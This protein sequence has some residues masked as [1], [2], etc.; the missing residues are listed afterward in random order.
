MKKL[1]LIIFIFNALV[2]TAQKFEWSAG[3]ESSN[4]PSGISA[5]SNH[6]SHVAADPS[7]NLIICGAY[8][9]TLMLGGDTLV[10]YGNTDLFLAKMDQA[11]NYLWK[12]TIGS[13]HQDGVYD[14]CVDGS[15]T[16]YIA[17]SSN[18]GVTVFTPDSAVALS[19]SYYNIM[20]FDSD[21][22]FNWIK[23]G[24]ATFGTE[25]NLAATLS[26]DGVYAAYAVT[27]FK[28]D[29]L[30]NVVW[31]K[32]GTSNAGSPGFTAISVNDNGRLALGVYTS[33]FTTS[34]G[35]FFFDTVSV[36]FSNANAS[37][38]VVVCDTSG[39]GL[40][41]DEYSA[42]NAAVKALAIDNA[43]GELYVAIDGSNTVIYFGGDTVVNPVNP[44][45]G[46]GGI[47]KYSSSGVPQWARAFYA[48]NSSML[49]VI[50]NPA[51]EVVFCG[52]TSN[53]SYCYFGPFSLPSAATNPIIGKLGSNGSYEWAKI[54]SRNANG[55][56]IDNAINI[57]NIPGNKY[58][59]GGARYD[60]FYNLTTYYQGCNAFTPVAY[61]SGHYFSV[62]S[63]NIEPVPVVN[64]KSYN[65]GLTV[66]FESDVQNGTNY[67]WNF[68]DAQTGT[69]VHPFHI[70]ADVG[71]YNVCLSADN[72]CGTG[73]YCQNVVL[74]GIRDVH[75][76]RIANT[77]Y[78]LVKVIGGFSST[79][80]LV[81]FIKSGSPD[82][83]PDSVLLINPG[84]LR[85]HLKLNGVDTGYYDLVYNSPSF[86]DTVIAA[87]HV[88]LPD[89]IL[90][91]INVTGPW[92]I[93]T[94]RW[95]VMKVTISNQ[96]NV[97]YYG[98]PVMMKLTP[99]VET[100]MYNHDFSDS[101]V[102][103]LLQQVPD[104]FYLVDSIAVAPFQFAAFLLPSIPAYS[105]QTI[106]IW[107]RTAVS[108]MNNLEAFIG[109]SYFSDS[110]LT[111]M[112]LRSVM[113]ACNFLPK[114]GQ[115]F[116][117]LLGYVPA[118]GCYVA[119][120]NLGCAIGNAIGE[121]DGEIADVI[122]NIGG[123]IL[124]CA[125]GSDAAGELLEKGSK[126]IIAGSLT[127]L[128]NGVLGAGDDCGGPSGCKPGGEDN[129]SL[130]SAASMDPNYKSGPQ[131]NT[132][133]NFINKYDEMNYVI[134]FE[135][136][137]T[138]T[139]PAAEVV[140]ID[141][142]DMNVFDLTTFSFTGF[143]ETDSLIDFNLPKQSFA[144]EIDLRPAK[145]AI[146]RIS[147]SLDTTTGILRWSFK[148]L[149][150]IT[151]DVTSVLADGFL[152]PNVTEP[153]GEGFVTYRIN[154][155]N[156]VT[157]L[158]S[159][160]NTAWIYFDGNAPVA[161]TPFLNTVDTVKPTSN[162]LTLPA[163]TND[164]IFT[165]MWT[166]ID[167]DAGIR[168]FDIYISINDGPYDKLLAMTTKDSIQVSGNN[169]DKYE[170]Y[171]IARD[172][173]KN[174]EAP[175]ANAATNPDAVTTIILTHIAENSVEGN[176][177]IHPNPAFNNFTITLN[178]AWEM[179]NVM[180]NIADV[181]GRVVHEQTLNHQ[182]SVINSQFSPGIYFVKV[183]DGEKVFTNKVVV[184]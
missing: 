140:V 39:S 12:E 95:G 183:M 9:D 89:S 175:P 52:E 57:T 67:Q 154:L 56:T 122:G 145:N 91:V 105:S 107:I 61:S 19:G 156:S 22:L 159:F 174:I 80:T 173:A 66:Y 27:A 85:T 43:T 123:T 41:G 155:K 180:L 171:S 13:I 112:G 177:S 166:G 30:G 81:K 168:S 103:A 102:Q 147:G 76:D 114:C 125:G 179:K 28:M 118:L 65:D 36:I 35:T 152:N 162:V 146:L 160:T 176:F 110:N 111:D 126:A 14:M 32:T 45:N 137:D 88:E 42:S 101:T 73:S 164:S 44:Q 6:Q 63:E 124:A 149:D 161:T 75:P 84:L 141:T 5:G 3:I 62:I 119:T 49:D 104:H 97:S 109:P 131:G 86:N 53:T 38:M 172:Y 25:I 37:K 4:I 181:T 163:T 153:E 157:H 96:S 23:T 184:E 68:G 132:P 169:G 74:D 46:F 82:I 31:Q 48:S 33:D 138:A 77:G 117:D 64:F 20:A 143:G 150:P 121:Q 51:G 99:D 93:R 106:N 26:A 8:S 40:W 130:P 79:P 151:Y 136:V 144:T 72:S 133:D 108:Q 100:F 90:P 158:Q 182:S 16:I 70:Y 71:S 170:F 10:T 129:W 167:A 7:G 1:L 55:N 116:L 148:S 47:L 58:L 139:A 178:K 92:A 17:F 83:I 54:D 120:A 134:H 50:I 87:L 34:I 11:G 15:G 127:D 115:C 98:M 29:N 165:V 60:F 24:Y 78:H 69:Q 21:G 142:L 113:S 2:A 94:I 135:N 128:I 18:F 59:V